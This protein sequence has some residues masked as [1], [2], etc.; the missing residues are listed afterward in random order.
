MR[1]G[2]DVKFGSQGPESPNLKLA[3]SKKYILAEI[4]NFNVH[5]IF[6][7]YSTQAV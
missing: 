4:A 7:L 3:K 5:Q 1:L 2:G 6:P